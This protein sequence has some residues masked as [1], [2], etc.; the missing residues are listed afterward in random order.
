M[1]SAN[2]SR[3]P[4]VSVVLAA[5]NAADTVE[6]AMRSVLAQT[7]AEL[8]LIVCDD[9]STDATLDVALQVRDPRVAVLSGPNRG[10]GAA[11]NRGARAGRGVLVA[12]LD[13]D[14]HW[15]PEKLERQVAYLR[16]HPDVVALG[17]LLRYESSSGRIFG[18]AGDRVGPDRQARVAQARFVP[19]PTS[20]L[21]V[22]RESFD[23][24]GGFD[25]L[26]AGDGGVSVEDVDL[27][28]RLA[29]VGTVE[30]LMEVLGVYRIHAAA[31]SASR[32]A[33][34]QERLR[35]VQARI[36]AGGDLDWTSFASSYCPTWRQR[37]A[38]FVN[39]TYRGSGLSAAEGRWARAAALG[40][41]SLILGPLYT[42]PRI[43][44]QQRNR[45]RRGGGLCRR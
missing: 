32:T 31:A 34:L 42:A 10:A 16:D 2:G 8:E 14:D 17:C 28:A 38:D 3:R 36:A 23:R 33:E 4:L 40:V 9:G 19:F 43:Y 39:A 13:G 44:R 15:L 5:Y 7:W 27:L 18:V 11:R 30:T 24:L 20:A 26:L 6:Q 37:K 21:A 29:A 12:F 25:E 22:R 45:L 35:F 1:L 41:L